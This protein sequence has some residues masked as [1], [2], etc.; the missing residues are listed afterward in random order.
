MI[1]D[2]D[3]PYNVKR[4][5]DTEVTLRQ[6]RRLESISERIRCARKRPEGP[7][8]PCGIAQG[9]RSCE[10]TGGGKGA[11]SRS[12]A[13]LRVLPTAAETDYG[14]DMRLPFSG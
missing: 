5:C 10:R 7:I 3:S 4:V 8:P 12:A 9:A 14:H 6:L 2:T 11:L 1:P 13:I